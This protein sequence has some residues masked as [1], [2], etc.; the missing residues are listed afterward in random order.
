M[1]QHYLPQLYL[2]RFSNNKKSVYAYDKKHSK[3]YQASMRAVCCEDNLYTISDDLIK[4]MKSEGGEDINSLLFEHDYFANNVEPMLLS[5][6]RLVDKIKDAWASGAS[7][8]RLNAGIKK[9]I[10]LHIATL[11]LRHPG[12]KDITIDTKVIWGKEELDMIRQFVGMPDGKGSIKDV[13][14]DIQGDKAVMHA[15]ETYLNYE[16]LTEMAE[17]MAD[18]IYVFWVR[19]EKDFYTSDFPIVVYNHIPNVKSSIN[20][21][22]KYGAE[23]S[24]PLS[25]DIMLSIYDRKYFKNLVGMDCSFVNADNQMVSWQNYLRYLYADEHIFSYKEDF[26]FIDYIYRCQGNKHKFLRPYQRI[27]TTYK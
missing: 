15:H 19:K 24:I 26:S 3:P 6:L 21:I 20:D 13:D 5:T 8:F 2:R 14:F 9:E 4:K 12:I 27:V 16:V 10:A 11:Y 1:K 22:I 25:P 18:N 23:L 7:H 17:S